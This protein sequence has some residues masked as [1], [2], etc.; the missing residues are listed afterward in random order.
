MRN[1][2]RDLVSPNHEIHEARAAEEAVQTETVQLRMACA[3]HHQEPKYTT[4]KQEAIVEKTPLDDKE[5]LLRQQ[6]VK[7][8][9]AQREGSLSSLEQRVQFEARK[10]KKQ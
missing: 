10:F 3:V 9:Q 2:E 7:E 6:A 1:V 8:R 4:T 5:V